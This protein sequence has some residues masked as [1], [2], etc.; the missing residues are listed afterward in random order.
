MGG[1][2]RCGISLSAGIV[3]ASSLV[4]TVEKALLIS[5]ALLYGL[6]YTKS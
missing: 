2:S 3:D 1:I 4:K 5:S 6:L